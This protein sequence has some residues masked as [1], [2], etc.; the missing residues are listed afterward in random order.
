MSQTNL[1]HDDLLDTMTHFLDA[2]GG[3]FPRF[4][5]D[6]GAYELYEVPALS[7]Y[8][9]RR[10]GANGMSGWSGLNQGSYQLDELYYALEAV[11]GVIAMLKRD[12][13]RGRAKRIRKQI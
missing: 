5:G 7:G 10:V 6:V 3:R 4:P 1:T 12:K 13:R 2:V 11:A 8:S 9:I